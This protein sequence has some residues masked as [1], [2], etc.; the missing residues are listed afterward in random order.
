MKGYNIRVKVLSGDQTEVLGYG[1]YDEDVSLYFFASP[2]TSD[3]IFS[4]T[5]PEEKPSDE[6]IAEMKEKGFHLVEHPN[7]PKIV[8][9]SGKVVYGC[10]VWW[11]PADDEE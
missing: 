6:L 5:N 11:A 8:M 4:E 2:E 1:N 10:Q 7:N 3:V 9:D